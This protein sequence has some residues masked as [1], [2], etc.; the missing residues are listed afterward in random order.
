[1]PIEPDAPTL[2]TG[3]NR[4]PPMARGKVRDLRVRW[5]LEEI[6]RP[7]A[8]ELFDAFQARPEDYLA[9]QPFGQVPAFDDGHVRLF[10]SGA[11]L[12]YLGEQDERLLPREPQERWSATA[13]AMAALNTIE[14]IVMTLVFVSVFHGDKPWSGAA[15]AEAVPL[16]HQRLAQLDAA[17]GD[18]EWLAGRFSIADILMV[19]VLRNLSADLLDP[20]SRLAAYTRR[21]EERPAFARALEAQLSQFE[22]TEGAAS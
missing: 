19:T 15:R 21:G 17:L 12:L 2:L 1:M 13:W 11:I 3:L 20:S 16:L 8:T 9:W 5:A 6:G 18:R 10:E 14:P 4:V 7:Y 22:P